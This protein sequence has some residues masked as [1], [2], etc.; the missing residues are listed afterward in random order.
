[1]AGIPQLIFVSHGDREKGLDKYDLYLCDSEKG[2]LDHWVA[3]S[4]H[5]LGQQKGDQHQR[6]GQ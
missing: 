3:T 4:S 6:G 1:M 5:R 2:H